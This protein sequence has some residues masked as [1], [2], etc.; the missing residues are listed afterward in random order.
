MS[1]PIAIRLAPE[2][3]SSIFQDVLPEEM[4]SVG[5][6]RF[7]QLQTVCSQWRN[8][9]LSTPQL[10]ASLTLIPSYPIPSSYAGTLRG[11]F[12]K[13]GKS[14]P[15]SLTLVHSLDSSQMDDI[16]EVIRSLQG[17]WRYLA[18]DIPYWDF[19]HLI[20]T[21]PRDRWTNLSHLSIPCYILD[22]QPL[23]FDPVEEHLL[24]EIPPVTNLSLSTQ[25]TP[26]DLIYPVAKD[27]VTR[28]IWKA[29]SL[30]NQDYS[31][32][33]NQYRHL[34]TLDFSSTASAWYDIINRGHAITLDML[35]SFSFA[36]FIIPHN[37]KILQQ[38][39]T[40]A[41]CKLH[42][43]FNEPPIESRTEQGENA[44]DIKFLQRA[45]RPYETFLEPLVTSSRGNLTI[46]SI[47]GQMGPKLVKSILVL[48]PDTVSNLSLQY[49]PYTTPF[50][51]SLPGS[52]TDWLPRLETLRVF[53]VPS[54][55]MSQSLAL[56]SVSSLTEFINGR[57]EAVA[58]REKLRSLGV[59][60]GGNSLFFTD[61]E[62]Q[63]MRGKGLKVTVWARAE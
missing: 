39:R 51:A 28:L 12:S 10:W 30:Y 32:W 1:Q 31:T 47:K 15:L 23:D 45:G 36:G 56:E 29:L 42:F 63:Y 57:L 48:L 3:L 13:A 41:L 46:V 19:W 53:E 40:P 35:R 7:W 8:V 38:F 25:Y 33:I 60:R 62:L 24:N 34:T 44:I 9:C 50:V 61:E 4:N 58:G 5:R 18:L 37:F 20:Q 49:W 2:L 54:P 43:T 11:W 55:R 59:T 22:I 52:T 21:S 16:I 14:T 6:A 17:R 27:S 26:P